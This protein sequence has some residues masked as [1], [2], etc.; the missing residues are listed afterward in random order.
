VTYKVDVPIFS[1]AATLNG[2]TS[3]C[4]LA[5]LAPRLIETG[6]FLEASLKRS[7]QALESVVAASNSISCDPAKIRGALMVFLDSPVH[8]ACISQSAAVLPGITTI[9]ASKSRSLIT[10]ALALVK[11]NT[12]FRFVTAGVLLS[13]LVYIIAHRLF[14]IPSLDAFQVSLLPPT[15]AYF[16]SLVSIRITIKS[17]SNDPDVHRLLYSTL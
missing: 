8:R 5:G 7:F 12:F 10:S 17:L 9:Y 2:A 4:S 13:P 15:L 1:V 14:G 16:S 3:V 11:F 6:D